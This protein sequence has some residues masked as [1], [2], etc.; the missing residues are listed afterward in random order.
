VA[1]KLG[2]IEVTCDAPPYRIVQACRRIDIRS[3]EDVRWLR[4]SEFRRLSEGNRQGPSSPW[5]KTLWG[6]G[7]RAERTCTCG[8]PL[9]CMSLFVFSLSTGAEIPYSLGQCARCRTVFWDEP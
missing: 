4:L 6:K 9:P 3:P 1:G 2:P 8:A 5:W 7:R